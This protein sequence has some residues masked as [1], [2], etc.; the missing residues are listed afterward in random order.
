[1]V[2]GVLLLDVCMMGKLGRECWK[3]ESGFRWTESG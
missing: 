3:V 2:A 1:M